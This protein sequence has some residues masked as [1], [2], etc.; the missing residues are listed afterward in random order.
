[1]NARSIGCSECRAIV[2]VVP[3]RR[4]VTASTVSP[5]ISPRPWVLPGGAGPPDNLGRP[6][7]VAGGRRRHRNQLGDAF[8]MPLEQLPSIGARHGVREHDC[9]TVKGGKHLAKDGE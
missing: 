9:G 4:I 1:M 6:R 7:D 5:A 3:S 8:A 2:I